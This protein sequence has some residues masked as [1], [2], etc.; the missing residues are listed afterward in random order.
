MLKE[1]KKKKRKK[2]KKN[3][4]FNLKKKSGTNSDSYLKFSN[5]HK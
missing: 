1:I 2:I 3:K 4:I 5:L